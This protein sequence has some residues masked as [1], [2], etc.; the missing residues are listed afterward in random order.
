MFFKSNCF[1][2]KKLLYC[3][4]VLIIFIFST[5]FIKHYFK[6]FFVIAI[7]LF[8]AYPLYN[9]L[10][11]IKILNKR[12]CGFISIIAVNAILILFLIYMGNLIYGVKD[13]IVLTIIK[14]TY[15]IKNI[16]EVLNIDFNTIY[17][18]FQKYYSNILNSNLLKKGALYTTDS[19]FNYF[20]GNIAAYFILVDKYVILNWIEQLISK[21]QIDFIRAKFKDVKTILKIEVTLVF[22][23]TIETIFG[24]AALNIENFLTLGIICGILDILPYIG[25]IVI[26]VP[27]ILYKIALKDYIIAIGLVFLYILL[28]VN[29]QIME[30]R[31]MSSTLKIHPL[32]TLIAFYLGL[33]TFGFIGMIM[34]P[35][36]VIICK[37]ILE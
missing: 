27:L 25:T 31:F 21:K 20:I 36:Y 24:F 11:K 7:V 18:Q 5:I 34:A 19:I 33:K 35:L 16:C 22:I 1:K 37:N 28:L 23:T 32:I 14:I 2:Y 10:C 30:T 9:L 13:L 4:I 15:T 17:G 29:R 6:P 26:F 12:L 3:I 8:M